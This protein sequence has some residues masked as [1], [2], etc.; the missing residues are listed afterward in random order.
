MKMT[1]LSKWVENTVGTG[2]IARYK[3]FLH[4]PQCFQDF[5]S[6][7]VKTRACLGKGF[8]H[9]YFTSIEKQVLT[10]YANLSQFCVLGTIPV[11]EPN[12]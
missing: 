5:Y 12:V 1:K 4:V 11:L 10:T 8:K 2:E 9:T 7:H 6:R 3:Q